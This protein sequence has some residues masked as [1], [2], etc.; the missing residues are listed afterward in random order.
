[1]KSDITTDIVVG[2]CWCFIGYPLEERYEP[3]PD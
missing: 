1:M 2:G 3:V